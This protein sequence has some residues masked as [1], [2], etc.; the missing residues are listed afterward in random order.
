MATKIIHVALPEELNGFVERTVKGGRYQDVSEVV[1]EALRRME[2]AE[3]AAELGQFEHA[4]AGGHNRAETQ[5]D[6]Q[7]VES[8]VRAG[9]KK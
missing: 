9:R 3:L 1:R 5:E 7:R 2:D 6:I 8:A 4:F